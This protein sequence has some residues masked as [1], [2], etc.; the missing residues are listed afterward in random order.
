MVDKIKK[1]RLKKGY[2]QEQ[3]A[4]KIGLTLNGYV[5]IEKRK[6]IPNIITGLKLCAAIDANPFYIFN[7]PK[8]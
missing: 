7:V 3:L 2:T 5:N 4:R 8:N 6:T 1:M